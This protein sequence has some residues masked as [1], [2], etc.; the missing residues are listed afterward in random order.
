MNYSKVIKALPKQFARIVCILLVAGVSAHYLLTFK[1]WLY[2]G[3]FFENPILN[4]REIYLS[5]IT[6]TILCTLAADMY[7]TK[8][9][10]W[11][12]NK[13]KRIGKSER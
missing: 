12:E 8:L 1:L 7:I 13:L 9:L 5:L 3:F 6:I 4:A 11:I 10:N 2:G